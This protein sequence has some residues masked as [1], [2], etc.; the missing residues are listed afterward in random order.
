MPVSRGVEID[1]E[2]AEEP[3][4]FRG[5]FEEIAPRRDDSLT[6]KRFGNTD[7]D[8]PARWS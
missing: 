1:I 7:A 5:E 2:I 4:A 3:L 8:L 6:L